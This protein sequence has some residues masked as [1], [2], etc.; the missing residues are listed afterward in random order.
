LQND[1]TT[2]IGNL[3]KYTGVLD[4]GDQERAKLA[5]VLADPHATTMQFIQ[6]DIAK[7]F[8]EDEQ[9]YIINNLNAREQ[10]MGL[11]KTLGGTGSDMQIA[12]VLRTIPGASTPSSDY[13][14]K[15]I[16]TALGV[17]NRLGKGIPGVQT[18]RTV[19]P[20]N[21]NKP[22]TNSSNVPSYDINGNPKKGK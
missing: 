4:R 18:S 22:A 9:N 21:K 3:K 11:R 8:D 6:S 2:S 13:A 15:Q 1:I 16:D 20:A 12:Q 7:N 19:N 14:N 17:V 10:I 5:A